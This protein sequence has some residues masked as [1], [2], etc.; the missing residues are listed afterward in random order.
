M[1]RL[2]RC[3]DG[4]YQGLKEDPCGEWESNG[5]VFLRDARPVAEG[6]VG[7][8]HEGRDVVHFAGVPTAS[9]SATSL[10]SP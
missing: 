1:E 6:R 5:H 7:V 10:S 3:R 9:E 8:A 4:G 2:R